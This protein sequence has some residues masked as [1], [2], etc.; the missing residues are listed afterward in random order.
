[1][2]PFSYIFILF[3]IYTLFSNRDSEERFSDPEYLT[4]A[5][6]SK[7]FPCPSVEISS[8]ELHCDEAE[9]LKKG[10]SKEVEAVVESPICRISVHELNASADLSCRKTV[11]DKLLDASFEAT[12][13]KSKEESYME[14]TPRKVLRDKNEAHINVAFRNTFSRESE[15]DLEVRKLERDIIGDL[16][17]TES[18][19]V[20]RER[21]DFPLD[22]RKVLRNEKE[23]ATDV[24]TM[25]I[26]PDL[27]GISPDSG[28]KKVLRDD[29]EH[30]FESVSRRIY[31][32]SVGVSFNT[33]YKKN[34]R[35][36]GECHL[37]ST[38][39][40]LAKDKMAEIV[41][42][43]PK[44]TKREELDYYA[45]TAS[46]RVL[47][48]EKFEALLDRTPDKEKKELCLESPISKRLLGEELEISAGSL[49][50]KVPRIPRDHNDS[51][52]DSATGK[53]AQDRVDVQLDL[54]KPLV[55]LPNSGAS[56]SRS[57]QTAQPDLM[58]T[59][60]GPWK[61]SS[62]LLPSGPLSLVYDG[63]LEKS[64]S[65]TSSDPPASTATLP[66]IRPGTDAETQL[67]MPAVTMCAELQGQKD[68]EK[69]R[70]SM[71]LK[72][73]FKKKNESTAE[74]V[75]SGV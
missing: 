32:D 20:Y 5:P 43:P 39:R 50:R 29:T 71:R 34:P 70:K 31:R 66:Q 62:D 25:K 48:R 72:N 22:V 47:P 7:R 44:T 12:L 15:T 69:S 2:S 16:T 33:N 40:A 59:S 63:I 11:K 46:T 27:M 19:K 55:P 51:S 21:S 13:K 26:S 41:K 8:K 75:Q 37:E 60:Q 54:P 23:T 57:A 74:N 18:R 52:T 64:Y 73:L 4:S 6:I 17:D 36:K 58:I 35:N 9:F 53:Q 38:V 45:A 56:E 42:A 10:K 61:S 24:V 49:R 65:M 30:P 1:M 14:A 28:T 3:F 67:S 68:K